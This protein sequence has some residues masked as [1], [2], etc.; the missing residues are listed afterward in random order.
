MPVYDV[1]LP[2]HGSC[3]PYRAIERDERGRPLE[4]VPDARLY[5]EVVRGVHAR[6]NAMALLAT[7]RSRLGGEKTVRK[8]F[9][10][11]TN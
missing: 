2:R 9:R 4:I 1:Y 8:P 6:S 10:G 7:L 5:P 3:V 11:Q